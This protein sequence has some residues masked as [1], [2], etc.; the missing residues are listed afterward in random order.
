MKYKLIKDTKET[1]WWRQWYSIEANSLK[2]AIEIAKDPNTE[3]VYGEEI[4]DCCESMTPYENNGE[5][6]EEIYWDDHPQRS[7]RDRILVYDNVNFNVY[8]DNT[9]TV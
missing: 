6:T 5:P 4:G 7:N 8:E 9:K 2:E 1:R 3:D